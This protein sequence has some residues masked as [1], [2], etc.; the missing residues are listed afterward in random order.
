[1]SL[2]LVNR[3]DS[4]YFFNPPVAWATLLF[5]ILILWP[6]PL[7]CLKLILIP[8]N[9]LILL[10]LFHRYLGEEDDG[11]SSQKSRSQALLEKLQKKARE[12]QNQ[13]STVGRQIF[14]E[15]QIKQKHAEKKRKPDK[16]S[17]QEHTLAKKNKLDEVSSPDF[18]SDYSEDCVKEKTKGKGAKKKEKK[19]S[20]PGS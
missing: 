9:L 2:F 19:K 4:F 15:E 5:N 8:V 1:M 14:T 13:R 6:C 12:R 7:Y 10:V 20:L 3:L 18:D 16:S 11:G 17:S